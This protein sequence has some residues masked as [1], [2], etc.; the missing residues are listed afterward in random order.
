MTASAARA[1]GARCILLLDKE[2]MVVFSA[3]AG[4]FTQPAE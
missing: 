1:P 2:R 4:F 3:A